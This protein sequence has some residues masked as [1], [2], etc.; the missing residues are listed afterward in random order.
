MHRN[1]L[2]T[3]FAVAALLAV[4]APVAECSA[5][6]VPTADA[7]IARHEAASGGAEA[8][9]K[10][11][12]IRLSGTVQIAD[13]DLKG[14]I[15]IL[16]G[17]GNKFVQKLVFSTIGAVSKGFDSTVAWV[18]DPQGPALL[19]GADA[20]AVETEANWYHAFL[21]PPG[22][23][24]A[25]VDSTE[26]GGEPAWQ[27]TYAAELGLEASVFFSR[28]SGLRLGETRA[29]PVGEVSTVESAYKDFGGVKLPTVVT[30]RTRAG[31]MVITI[32]S[33]EFDRVPASALAL[34]PQVRAL[35]KPR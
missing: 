1:L 25:R 29:L 14:T 32:D 11:T 27:L 12:S 13:G 10:H 20:D 35:I 9:N 21:A 23:R 17:R 18:I 33:V 22:L 26:F 19:T 6:G 31:S 15:E 3:P 8:L 4:I 16:R 2:A 24:L 7:L 5:Q 30:N 34:P 28:A